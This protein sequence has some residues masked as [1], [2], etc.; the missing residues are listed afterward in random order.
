MQKERAQ[1]LLRFAEEVAARYSRTDRQ[2]NFNAESFRVAK[3]IPLSDATASVIYSKTPGD[4]QA[5]FFFY[6]IGAQARW[7]YFVPTDSHIAGMT[8][9]AQVKVEVER[10]N[11]DKNFATE[12]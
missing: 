10:E 1:S 7:E 6:W 11:W 3:V 2:N 8:Q 12:Q 9:F 4:K 5:A